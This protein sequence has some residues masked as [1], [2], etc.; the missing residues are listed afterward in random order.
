MQRVR[1]RDLAEALQLERSTVAKALRGDPRI[2]PAT[3]AAVAAAAERLGYQPDPML[4]ALA[5]YRAARK[6]AEVQ[7]CL[8]WIYNHPRSVTMDHFP[9]YAEYLVGARR[10][11]TRL[12]Y[13]I[14]EFWV[15]RQPR[16]AE[17]LGRALLARGVDTLVLAPQ[18]D[19]SRPLELPWDRLCT[20]AIGYSLKSPE[21][22]RVT[23]DHFQAMTQAV[24]QL[25]ARGY[26]RIGCYLWQT[27]NDRIERRALS[28]F[29]ALSGR[30]N[31]AVQLYSEFRPKA[32]LQ[33]VKSNRLDAVLTRE[34]R[35]P[36]ILHGATRGGAA[37]IGVALY[38][39]GL[40]DDTAGF[41]YANDLVGAAAVDLAVRQRRHGEFGLPT[42]PLRVLLSARWLEGPTHKPQTAARLVPEEGRTHQGEIARSC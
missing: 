22:H 18:E 4:S 41:Y 13:R 19:L 24:E 30:L 17:R 12:G 3:R 27:D 9:A 1:Q 11:A 31:V 14:E 42:N 8:G 36:E 28:A 15:G 38:T 2:A 5:A 34:A 37:A 26:R 33:W 20:V 32:F 6:P 39:R 29:L 16:A 40:A 10:Q 23:I 35:V 25:A 21:L 7:S